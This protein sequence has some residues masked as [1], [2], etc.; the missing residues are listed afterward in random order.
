MRSEEILIRVSQ[1]DFVDSIAVG[2]KFKL[3]PDPENILIHEITGIDPVF[4]KR[5]FLNGSLKSW[6]AN[7]LFE[8]ASEGVYAVYV[9]SPLTR[10]MLKKK[11]KQQLL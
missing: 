7:E 6:S 1:R 10:I 11:M 9:D 3:G 8:R 4:K 2:S 5:F